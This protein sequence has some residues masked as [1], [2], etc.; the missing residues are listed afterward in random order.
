MNALINPQALS[1]APSD[2]HVQ[3]LW[4]ELEMGGPTQDTISERHIPEKAQEEE[5][6]PQHVVLKRF[7]RTP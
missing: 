7:C 1:I 6:L 2:Q 5:I 3:R 4:I